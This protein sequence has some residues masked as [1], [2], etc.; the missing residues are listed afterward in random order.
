MLGFIVGMLTPGI[1]VSKT[2]NLHGFCLG[3]YA[4][5]QADV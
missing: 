5:H 3:L 2:S 1:S 4:L